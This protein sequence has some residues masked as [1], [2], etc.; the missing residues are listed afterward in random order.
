[1]KIKITIFDDSGVVHSNV[2]S[3][4]EEGELANAIG[5]A[6]AEARRLRHSSA[7]NWQIKVEELA[8]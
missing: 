1:L 8:E 4:T 3:I 6:L 2:V 7:W 5:I